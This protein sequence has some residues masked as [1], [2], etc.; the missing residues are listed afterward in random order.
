MRKMGKADIKQEAMKKYRLY[1]SY[2]GLRNAKK[3]LWE[4]Y[5]MLRDE[6]NRRK[7]LEKK[8]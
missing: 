3:V 4:C 5:K 7:E 6:E 1:I 2:H 8:K